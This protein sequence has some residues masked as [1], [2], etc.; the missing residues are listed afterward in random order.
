MPTPK[1]QYYIRTQIAGRWHF[2]KEIQ[3]SPT[4]PIWLDEILLSKHTPKLYKTLTQ[5]RNTLD[6]H[7]SLLAKSEAAV[8][9]EPHG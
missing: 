4:R 5:A 6:I 2:L 8:W 3:Y 1:P 7:A 9:K